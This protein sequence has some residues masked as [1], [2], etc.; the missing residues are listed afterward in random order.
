LSAGRRNTLRYC[1]LRAEHR[2]LEQILHDRYD[3]PLN[4]IR[5][6]SPSNEDIDIYMDAARKYLLE[7]GEK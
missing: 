7:H 3:P 1:A 2:G 6:I 5:P 4:K